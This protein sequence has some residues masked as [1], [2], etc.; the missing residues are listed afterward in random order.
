MKLL[1]PVDAARNAAAPNAARPATA[2][3]YDTPDARLIVFR[4]APG[5]TVPPHRNSSSVLLT[6]LEGTGILSG[7]GEPGE[8]ERRCT[9][10]EV[11]AYPPNELHGIRAL[12]TELLV[13]ATITPRPGSR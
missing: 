6:V 7:E 1:D 4:L 5:Q 12:D 2:V 13:L 10:G 8:T 3:V 9:A 11:M